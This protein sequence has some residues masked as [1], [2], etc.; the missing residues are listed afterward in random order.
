MNRASVS[1]KTW[2]KSHVKGKY[3]LTCSVKYTIKS[4]I[5]WENTCRKHSTHRTRGQNTQ[6][7]ESGNYCSVDW[8]SVLFVFGFIWVLEVNLLETTYTVFHIL[9]TP[10]TTRLSPKN[11]RQKKKKRYLKMGKRPGNSTHLTQHWGDRGRGNYRS[12]QGCTARL[13]AVVELPITAVR[14]PAQFLQRPTLTAAGRQ[15][16][17]NSTLT[18]YC[19]TKKMVSP[20]WKAVWQSLQN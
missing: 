11:Q 12:A 7:L 9:T 18:H 4:T 19:T 3:D 20:L 15:T 16:C 17:S 10:F 5:L 6:E 8:F 2:P 1:H 14:C 13:H